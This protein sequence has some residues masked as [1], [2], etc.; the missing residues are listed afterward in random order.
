M[1]GVVGVIWGNGEAEYFCREHWTN[2]KRDLPDGQ[3]D[4]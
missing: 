4:L 3:R 2:R 1:A